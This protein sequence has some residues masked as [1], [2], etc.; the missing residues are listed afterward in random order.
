MDWFGK[1]VVEP[2]GLVNW[3]EGMLVHEEG[4]FEACQKSPLVQF[5]VEISAVVGVKVAQA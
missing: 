5:V 2:N 4:L 1:Y 3:R